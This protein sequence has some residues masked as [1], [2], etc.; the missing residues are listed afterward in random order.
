MLREHTAKNPNPFIVKKSSSKQTS[1]QI[2]EY[3]LCAECENLFSKRGET[4]VLRNCFRL[5]SGFQLVDWLTTKEPVEVGDVNVYPAK[6]IPEI[7]Q[8]ALVYFAASVFWRAAVRS[9]DNCWIDIGSLY[10]ESLRQYLLGLASFPA[11]MFL[12]IVLAS[13]EKA[14]A[15]AYAPVGGRQSSHHFYDFLIPG[16]RFSLYI[17][18]KVPDDLRRYCVV[19]SAEHLISVSDHIV[20]DAFSRLARVARLAKQPG[21]RPRR[22]V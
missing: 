18:Q 10:Q 2:Q 22:K 4:W 6:C 16:I 17:G 9:W 21:I 11:S 12:I 1:A 3:L 20:D 8:D 14:R 5:D 19:G 13:R 7:K 15:V